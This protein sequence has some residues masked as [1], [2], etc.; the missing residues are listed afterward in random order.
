ME[1]IIK[2]NN[3]ALPK[4]PFYQ[5]YAYDAPNHKLVIIEYPDKKA[6]GDARRPTR[7]PGDAHPGYSRPWGWKIC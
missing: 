6:A 1:K 5:E 2:A 7:P 3:I 4:L